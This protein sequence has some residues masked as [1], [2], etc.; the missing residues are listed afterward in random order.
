MANDE[1]VQTLDDETL[2][3]LQQVRKG[4]P[5]KFVML[6]KGVKIIGLVVFK[7]GTCDKQVKAAKKAVGTGIPYFGVV[8]PQNLGAR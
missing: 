1:E 7:K 4:K 5:R 8:R 6:C 3:Q 2:E